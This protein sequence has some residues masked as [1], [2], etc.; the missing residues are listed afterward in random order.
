MPQ[1]VSQPDIASLVPHAGAMVLLVQV[2]EFGPETIHCRATLDPSSNPLAI[3]GA[4][5]ATALAEFG[6]QAMAVHGAMLAPAGTP[7]RSGRLV[8]LG[9]LDLAINQ[10]DQAMVLDVHATRLGGDSSGQMYAFK[11]TAGTRDLARGQAT[12]MFADKP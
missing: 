8:A 10:V 1:P 3:E 2:V 5:P 11:I 9:Q 12:V 6:A 4:L 7:P